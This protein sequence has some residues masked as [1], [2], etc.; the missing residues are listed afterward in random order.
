MRKCPQVSCVPM[1]L[2]WG[3][4][5]GVLLL[6][7]V[8]M[9]KIP[10]P[11]MDEVHILEM[12]RHVLGFSSLDS[13]YITESNGSYLLPFYYLGPALQEGFYRLLG[14]AGPRLSSMVGLL[15]AAFFC[16][17]WLL[18]RTGNGWMST[19][20]A[21]T[22][23]THP[24]LVQSVR[25][26][27]IDSWACA[28]CFISV[29]L[30]SRAAT[31]S[32]KKQP[33]IFFLLGVLSVTGVFIWPS[34]VLFFPFYLVE[35]INLS[36]ADPSIKKRL[37][38]LFFCAVAGAL[39]SALVLLLPIAHLVRII[40][41]GLNTYFTEFQPTGATISFF[42]VLRGLFI[43]FSKEFLRAPFFFLLAG[44]G[45]LVSL[46]KP[47]LMTGFVVA[48]FVGVLSTL[49][50]FRLLYLIPFFMLFALNGFQMLS[51]K[52]PRTALFFIGCLLA[53]GFSTG[54][55][56]YAGMSLL[57]KGRSHELMTAR[58]RET[59][60]AGPLRVYSLTYQDY[61]SARELGWKHSRYTVGSYI[62]DDEKHAHLLDGVDFV[63][64]SQQL[65]Y[66]A[67]E[68]SFTFYSLFF[69]DVMIRSAVEEQG[70]SGMSLSA[71]TGQALAF[72]SL[73]DKEQQ[74]FD[75]KLISSGFK[76][77]AVIDLTVPVSAYTPSQQWILS[78]LA[79]NPDYD[80]LIVWARAK[81]AEQ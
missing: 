71:K 53:Y 79:V 9:F 73:S 57:L 33:Y 64:D 2:F 19:V 59:V 49:H 80:R 20:L 68:E 14:F 66:Y 46:R 70:N 60:G 1:V 15:A 75:K 36:N 13:S 62:F 32:E 76:I 43:C 3:V 56:A 24:L 22:F 12:G 78:K 54:S 16:R 34:A 61:Y 72:A 42:S 58:L 74:R 63:I 52:T 67:V 30:L 45:L 39:T 5:L 18:K 8:S 44:F 10:L 37:I 41:Q 48:L 51:K 38:R 47:V 50:S 65:P 4:W 6:H 7:F 55:L 28:V 77:M 21:L 29:S 81:Q 25:S 40:I 69:R 23:L 17:Q 11:W 27:R 26:V 31:L 35:L